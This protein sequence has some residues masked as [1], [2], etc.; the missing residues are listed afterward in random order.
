MLSQSLRRAALGKVSGRGSF[1]IWIPQQKTAVF[2]GTFEVS[3]RLLN[4][5]CTSQKH[6]NALIMG[7]IAVAGTAVTLKYALAA[8]QNYEANK[9]AVPENA[10]GEGQTE[11]E[12][13]TAKTT[14]EKPAATAAAS[15][16]DPKKKKADT[17]GQQAA[18]QADSLF[19]SWFARN[20]YDGGFEDKMT[21][22]EAALILGIRESATVE[23]VKEAHRRVLLLN[24]PDRGGSA[25]VA[26]KV[27]EA[28]DLLLKGR[29]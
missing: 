11:A 8:Y 28:K 2:L 12:A 29:V 13:N 9:P 24:H 26:A 19:S 23:K 18:K 15:R 3:N 16:A 4:Q 5:Y 22:R 10:P 25:F 1:G 7:G 6:E 14:A 21:K 27:N 17:A 20:F